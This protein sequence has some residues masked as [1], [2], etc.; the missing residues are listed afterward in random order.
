LLPTQHVIGIGLLPGIQESAGL[1]LAVVLVD[2][3]L[4]GPLQLLLALLLVQLLLALLEV[5][6]S[7]LRLVQL[8][9]VLVAA[10]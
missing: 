8:L 1:P 6:L 5:L 4:L 7:A 3:A 9:L 10:H 2:R